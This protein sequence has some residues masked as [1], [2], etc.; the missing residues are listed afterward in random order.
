MTERFRAET[1]AKDRRTMAERQYR[2][3]TKRTVDRLSVNSCCASISCRLSFSPVRSGRFRSSTCSPAA[4]RS[5][6][7]GVRAQQ[8]ADDTG[9]RVHVSHFPPGTSK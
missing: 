3:L 6:A 8:F 5:G 7:F 4:P 2:T 9:V 1:A